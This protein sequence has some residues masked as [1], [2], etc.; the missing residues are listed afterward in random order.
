[1]ETSAIGYALFRGPKMKFANNDF[2]RCVSHLAGPPRGL[3][4][5]VRVY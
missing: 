3:R 4:P 5:Q 2:C 1:M